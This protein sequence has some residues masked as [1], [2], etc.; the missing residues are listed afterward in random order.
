MLVNDLDLEV[1]SPS[2]V[3]YHPWVLDPDDPSAPAT[4]GVDDLNN[5][6]QVLVPSPES[7]TWT[8]RVVATLLPEP[9]QDFSLVTNVGAPP[10][11]PPAAP[12]G[13]GAEPGANEGEIQLSWNANA[14]P[15]FDHY[16]L[17]RD[18]TALFGA[19]KT[20]FEIAGE[21]YLDTGR[22]LGTTYFYRLFAVDAAS[23]ESAPSDTVSLALEGTGVPDLSAASLALIRPNPF[24]SETTVAYTVPS[25]GAAVA[26]RVYDV[27]GRLVRTLAEGP[28][29]GGAHSAVWDGRDS[30]GRIVSPGIYFCR[31]E[32][33]GWTEVRK[34]VLLR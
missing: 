1:V 16:R 23:N 19:G 29:G 28:R 8:V 32:I 25:A 17:E 24:T 21:G 27:R 34:V 11:A 31:A 14:E 15:D 26:V 5:V 22:E 9:D 6:E 7:G 3:T 20:S 13:L 2:A 4:T 12:T 33:G 18:T 30:S 10:D